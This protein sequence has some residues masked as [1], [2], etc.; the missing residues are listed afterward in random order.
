M[1]VIFLWR[2]LLGKRVGCNRAGGGGGLGKDIEMEVIFFTINKCNNKLY[3][4]TK[5]G[6]LKKC[7]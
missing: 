2:V 6:V 4:L 5:R 7:G 3:S 1:Q